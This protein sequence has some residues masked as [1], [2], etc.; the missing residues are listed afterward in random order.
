MA[1]IKRAI[2]ISF[3]FL[4]LI[5]LLSVGLVLANNSSPVN[6]A[7]P[8]PYPSPDPYPAVYLPVIH[9]ELTATLTPVP[10]LPPLPTPTPPSPP[11]P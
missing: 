7:G 9:K 6:L 8:Y 2:E 11:D 5:G 10:T 4:C 3:I 1:K